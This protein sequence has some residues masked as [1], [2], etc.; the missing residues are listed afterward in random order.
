MIQPP[1][2]QA[3]LIVAHPAHELRVLRWFES[4]APTLA[5]LT[6]GSRNGANRDR[7]E[8]TAVLARS[9]GA[10]LSGLFGPMLDRELY[11]LVAAGTAEPLHACAELLRDEMVR[12]GTRL[13]V[14][15]AW[16][17]YSIAHDLA[18]LLGRIAAAEAGAQT[19]RAI[20]VV[21]FA[22]VSTETAPRLDQAPALYGL[23]LIHI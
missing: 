8:R 18:H 2:T 11:S 5:V 9:V 6:T 12:D 7:L 13:A 4:A 19:G 17:G 21:E 1:S 23:S 16:Q 20:E 22:P 10:P 14:V 3:M 15:D